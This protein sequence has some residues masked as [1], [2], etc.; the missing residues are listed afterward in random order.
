MPRC[1]ESLKCIVERSFSH[2]IEHAE[3]SGAKF[4]KIKTNSAR[5]S[6]S[7]KLVFEHFEPFTG[8]CSGVSKCQNI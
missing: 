1:D 2:A 8:K 7:K 3:Y 5:E 4:L 6:S